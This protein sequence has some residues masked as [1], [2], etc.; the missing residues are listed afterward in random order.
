M[1]KNS[2]LAVWP[3]KSSVKTAIPVR[4][5]SALTSTPEKLPNLCVISITLV[6][7]SLVSSVISVTS[8][9]DSAVTLVDESH[10][11]TEGNIGAVEYEID[12]GQETIL[13]NRLD[14]IVSTTWRL[15]FKSITDLNLYK[16]D[17][18]NATGTLWTL[19]YNYN[20]AKYML[21]QTYK[22]KY[23]GYKLKTPEQ[24]LKHVKK[25]QNMNTGCKAQLKMRLSKSTDKSL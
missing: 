19:F 11:H 21:S 16:K 17:Y 9:D 22:C 12:H 6:E 20:G 23:S 1:D 18:Q 3:K 25:T 8:A 10:V 5:S 7:D 2:G 14:G 24:I 15:N 13:G 4:N